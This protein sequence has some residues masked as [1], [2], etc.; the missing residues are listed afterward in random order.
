MDRL[1][2]AVAALDREVEE[3]RE[4]L[5]QGIFEVPSEIGGE[6]AGQAEEQGAE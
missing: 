3:R 6:R 2:E 4:Q 1:P 5:L